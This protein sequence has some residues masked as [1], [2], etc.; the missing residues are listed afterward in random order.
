MHPS[1]KSLRHYKAMVFTIVVEVAIS[2]CLITNAFGL[3]ISK[4]GPMYLPEGT[5]TSASLYSVK[6]QSV[7]MP[8]EMSPK[9]SNPTLDIATLRE[10]SGNENVSEINSLPLGQEM[11]TV[12]VSSELGTK[13]L[14]R[15]EVAVYAGTDGYLTSLGVRL[16]EGRGLTKDDMADYDLQKDGLLASSVVITK[17]LAISIFG[18][19]SALG[20]E[21]FY[22]SKKDH[23][24]RIVGVV[25]NVLKPIIGDVRG[26]QDA[27][28]E[29]VRPFVGGIYLFRNSLPNNRDRPREAAKALAA[30]EAGRVTVMATSLDR[31]RRKYFEE[32]RALSGLLL[33]LVTVIL[34][35]CWF[36]VAGI[37]NY[38]IRQR[39]R[40]IGIR[41]ALGAAKSDI[42]LQFVTE[43]LLVVAGG[44]VIGAP[45]AILVNRYMQ[46]TYGI[47]GVAVPFLA[48]AAIGFLATCLGS[49]TFI[50]IAALRVSPMSAVRST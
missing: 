13:R 36:G 40:S 41:R 26:S 1:I 27:L 5:A 6:M 35:V 37:T 7:F 2:F 28:F 31:I 18:T 23:S 8:H 4:V 9:R 32:D 38:W 29:T 15:T 21:L 17:S 12:N 16:I 10:Q 49:V 3:F 30:L 48:A 14:Q 46:A 47:P 22:G 44:L 39:Y 42:A 45:V 25:D 19:S 33:A 11:S 50:L 43:N 20:K 34:A 24:V